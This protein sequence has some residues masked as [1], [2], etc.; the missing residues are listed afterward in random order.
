NIKRLIN[1]INSLWD[2]KGA[3][4]IPRVPEKLPL[5]DFIE[6]NVSIDLDNNIPIGLDVGEFEVVGL[7]FNSVSTIPIVGRSKSGKSSCM[8]SIC[9]IIN[10]KY[11]DDNVTTY[12][13]DS[14]SF[15]LVELE[16]LPIVSRYC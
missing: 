5:H 8:S 15:G 7:D 11:K 12:V 16:E 14:T 2:K 6:E 13:F 9:Q 4:K 1:K 3:V 10:K